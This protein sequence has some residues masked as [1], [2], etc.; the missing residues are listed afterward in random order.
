MKK[1]L[2]FFI[3][4]YA[5][6]LRAPLMFQSFSGCHGW[7]EGHY[8]MTALNFDRYG[9]FKQ[10]NDLG[11]DY[12]S[13]PLVPWTVCLSFKIFG[14][15]EGAAR[16][17]NFI[18]GL[19]SIYLLFLIVRKLYD[20]KT[21]WLSALFASSAP[22]IVYFS[23]NLQ[24]D[25]P[26]LFFL[27]LGIHFALKYRE[28]GKT[29]FYFLTFI[30]AGLSVFT[31]YPA[32]LGYLPLAIILLTGRP[33]KNILKFVLASVA[34]LLPVFLWLIYC[35]IEKQG[36]TLSY[37]TRTAEY[38][39]KTLWEAMVKTPSITSEHLGPLIVFFALVG[40]FFLVKKISRH[41][42]VLLFTVIWFFLMFPYP[43][44]YLDNAYYDYPALYG[45]CLI[46]GIGAAELLRR[47]KGLKI[48]TVVLL[49]ST[50]LF[51]MIKTYRRII[52]FDKIS[53]ISK[54]SEPSSFY[55]AKYAAKVRAGEETILVDYPPT[56]FYAGGDPK[57]VKCVYG[58]TEEFIKEKKYDYIVL[59]YFYG[60]DP[61]RVI[62]D[63]KNNNYRQVAPLAWKLVR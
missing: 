43:L 38:S 45:F 17:P 25:S 63:L 37:F 55:S 48:F 1:Y 35:S 52:K 18:F 2:I 5:F 15:S 9:F 46:A 13:T 59:N 60:Y 49:G 39:L 34:S 21:A 19:F 33:A 56:M 11:E 62:T 12:T 10:M 8:A 4:F 7:N 3:L 29:Y 44:A 31:K 30:F 27:L 40:S 24:L 51:G 54:L 28:T 23:R 47:K 53:A 14:V 26:F 32:L 42:F 22:G 58:P 41:L 36:Q 61:D 50:I 6:C 57:F 16:L 20:E